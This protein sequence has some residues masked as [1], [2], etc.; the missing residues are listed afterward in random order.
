MPVVESIL[1]AGRG[2]S[3]SLAIYFASKGGLQ[4]LEHLRVQS[5][6]IFGA[7][8]LTPHSFYLEWSGPLLVAVLKGWLENPKVASHLKLANFRV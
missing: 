2:K 1:I 4:A 7:S 6:A 3:V 5:R 8:C